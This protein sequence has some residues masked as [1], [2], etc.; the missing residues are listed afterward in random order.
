[1]S[2]VKSSNSRLMTALSTKL[3]ISFFLSGPDGYTKYWRAGITSCRRLETHTQSWQHGSNMLNKRKVYWVHW[4]LISGDLIWLVYYFTINYADCRIFRH[5]NK[6]IM[7]VIRPTY[8][9]FT[10]KI[11]PSFISTFPTST[12]STCLFCWGSG[13]PGRH[14]TSCCTSSAC[15]SFSNRG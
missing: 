9:H 3:N 7:L 15:F 5:L 13:L 4:L 8:Q 2:I 1:M 6:C 10:L 14:A 11:F 12:T